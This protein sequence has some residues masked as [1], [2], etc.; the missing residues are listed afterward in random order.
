MIRYFNIWARNRH[1]PTAFH[2]VRYEDLHEDAGR[3]LRGLLDFLGIG[4][5]PDP[6]I[7][8]AVAMASFDNMR[9]MELND[10]LGSGRL[11][12]TDVNDPQSYKTRR[13]KVGGYVD[14]LD[15][16]DIA[17]LNNRVRHELDP[18]FGYS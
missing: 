11:R 16:E 2:L 15:P 7:H 12:P 17:S 14:Y 8:D 9:Q 3:E 18:F 5:V 6:V 10:S 1:I 4:D 13:G